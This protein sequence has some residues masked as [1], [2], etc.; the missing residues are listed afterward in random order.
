MARVIVPSIPHHITQRGA[1]RQQTFFSLADEQF[2]LELMAEW[3]ARAG[4]EIWASCLM[5]NHVHLIYRPTFG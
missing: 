1:R 3:C 2:C 5:P 4:I